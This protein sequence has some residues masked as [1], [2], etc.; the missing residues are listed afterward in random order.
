MPLLFDFA[1]RT[2]C[3]CFTPITKTIGSFSII[4]KRFCPANL[5]SYFDAG[6]FEHRGCLF[7]TILPFSDVGYL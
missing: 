2:H 6:S 3:T 5:S 4:F 7:P 1:A